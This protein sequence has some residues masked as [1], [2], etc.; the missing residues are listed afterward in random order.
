MLSTD[1][2]AIVG[3]AVP[4]TGFHIPNETS[5]TLQL[6]AMQQ[7]ALDAGISVQEINGA[8]MPWS[9][10]GGSAQSG[11]SNWARVLGTSFNWAIEGGF[12]A[13][14][15]RALLHA[16]AAIQAGLCE[17]VCI[18]HALAGGRALSGAERMIAIHDRGDGQSDRVPAE[19]I[20]ALHEFNHPY[21]GAGMPHRSALNARRHMHDYGTTIE[22]IAEV[23]ATIRNYGHIN[24]EAAMFGRGPYS[25][26]DVLASRWIAE[27]LHL[28]D[29]SIAGQG[30]AAIVVTSGQ[31]ARQL[32]RDPVYVLGGAIE[33]PRGTHADP[34]RNADV[35][36][37]GAARL[38]LSFRQAGVTRDDVDVLSLY[39]ATS[40]EII[41]GLEL[42]RFCEPG[43]GGPFV[44]K[45]GLSLDGRLPTNTDGGLLAHGWAAGAQLLWKVIEGVRQLR[46][47]CGPRQVRDAEVAVCMN[48]VPAAWHIESAIL[49][50]G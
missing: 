11:T 19:R 38:D 40:F 18:S 7:A 15:I 28:L 10:P 13:L 26:G 20:E 46:G 36:G 37:M 35:A 50:R 25:V 39:D 32:R 24:P 49:G 12:D 2:V 33:I 34:A 4:A 16:A 30:G 17:T 9:G 22:Q 21:G 6:K 31:R 48:S 8:C 41:A 5:T 47:E 1:P 43:E 23:S 27:P 44:E 42:L 29:C 3:V 14:G 45:G